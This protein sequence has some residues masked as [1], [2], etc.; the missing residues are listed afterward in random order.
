MSWLTDRGVVLEPRELS[1]LYRRSRRARLFPGPL[2]HAVK[3][4]LE[5]AGTPA[6][7][8]VLV[9]LIR[10]SSGHYERSE[11]LLA[12]LRGYGRPALE[13]LL[14]LALDAEVADEI[15]RWLVDERDPAVIRRLAAAIREHGD[16]GD[17]DRL[18]AALCTRYGL[19]KGGVEL[20]RH[21]APRLPWRSRTHARR[22]RA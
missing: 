1:A 2:A 4:R 7:E 5:R 8:E 22:A 17:R 21:G 13:E 18:I 14:S 19:V 10:E 9:A 6:A 15:V 16:E 20:R 3:S 11:L 12:R